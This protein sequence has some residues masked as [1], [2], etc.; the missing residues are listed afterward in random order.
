VF[1]GRQDRSLGRLE[2]LAGSIVAASRAKP[3][4]TPAGT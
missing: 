2:A 4:A 1:R 3:A